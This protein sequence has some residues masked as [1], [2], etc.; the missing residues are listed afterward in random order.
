MNAPSEF[1]R[2]HPLSPAK[3]RK[4]IF[5]ALPKAIFFSLI[6]GGVGGLIIVLGFLSRVPGERALYTFIGSGLLSFLVVIAVYLTIYGGYVHLYIRRYYYDANDQFLTIQKGVFAPREIHVNY[7][8]IQDVYVD[9]DIL[10]RLMG[11]YDVHIASATVASGMEAHIDGVDAPVAE[12]LKNMLLTSIG[13]NSSAQ[14]VMQEAQPTRSVPAS[15]AS[16]FSSK[17]YPIDGKYRITAVL[18]CA[19][20]AASVTALIIFVLRKSFT[21]E[22]LPYMFFIWL[23]IWIVLAI[24]QLVWLSSFYFELTPQFILM[25]SGIIAR[26]EKHVPYRTVQDVILSRNFID[27]LLG[28]STVTVENAAMA[29]ARDRGA[30]RISIF[31]QT[32][33]RAEKLVAELRRITGGG[34]S[35]GTG[36]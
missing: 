9:Q 15:A 10:D 8:K 7:Q 26:Q 36:L 28:L 29:N 18:S 23:A 21:P 24:Y 34:T 11:L 17:E 25:R 1:Q 19:F 33:E 32:P 35:A 16:G 3:F 4:K 30:A 22:Y 6:L 12:A 13:L 31:G 14:S 5:Q 2:R 27:Q 20:S